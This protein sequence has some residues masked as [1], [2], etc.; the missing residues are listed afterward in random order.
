MFLF[1]ISI[2]ASKKLIFIFKRFIFIF[3]KLIFICNIFTF[4]FN[5]F[6]FIFNDHII[7]V[8]GFI[9]TFKDPNLHTR[10]LYLSANHC[11]FN[12][13]Y[14]YIQVNIYSRL[15]GE[16]D[17][18]RRIDQIVTLPSVGPELTTTCPCFRDHAGRRKQDKFRRKRHGECKRS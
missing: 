14:N 17:L 15:F 9:I 16:T 4:T 12:H 13:F 6:I 7:M 5:K 10:T 11:A 3:K 1:N 18:V 2:F 8:N